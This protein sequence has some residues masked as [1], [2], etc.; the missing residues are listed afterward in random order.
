[1]KRGTIWTWIL[2]IVVGAGAV[3]LWKRTRAAGPEPPLPADAARLDPAVGR[4]VREVRAAV[5]RS[6]E[7][8]L[9]WGE[10]GMVYE[11]NELLD[12]AL[13]SYAR[14]AE[15]APDEVRWPYRRARVCRKLGRIPEAIAGMETAA[16][17]DP[18]VSVAHW[19]LGLLRL[20]TAD[21]PGAEANFLRATS[22]DP[23]DPAGWIGLARVHLLREDSRAAIEA[24]RRAIPL[25]ENQAYAHLLLGRALQLAGRTDE[26]LAELALGKAEDPMWP[27]PFAEEMVRHR[28]GFNV[29]LDHARKLIF[30]GQ[31]LS[32]IPLLENLRRAQPSDPAVINNLS[33][34]YSRAGRMQEARALL[35]EGLANEPASCTMRLNL[36]VV[37]YREGKLDAALAEIDRALALDPALALAHD[38]KGCYLFEA[39]RYPEALAAF[40]AELA[41][42]DRNVEVRLWIGENLLALHRN[43]EAAGTFEEL[44]R[45]QPGLAEAWFGLA[46]ARL[47]LR[48]LEGANAAL[49]ETRRLGPKDPARL[50]AAFVE[51]EKR[52]AAAP[53]AG[54][55]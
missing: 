38:L 47:G 53:A 28:V 17:L 18:R 27:D 35:E 15:L 12:P 52:R 10:L 41:C 33:D 9:A 25:R 11:A 22:V 5:L 29:T 1:M 40:R 26:A 42:D 7:S 55:R 50:A 21:L 2:V 3:I 31:P 23:K 48:E 13:P 20:E 4:R 51:L 8:P 19:Q 32:A 36:A 44:T 39:K 14:A 24:L 49:I 34:A 54:K 46:R 37:L 43:A 6:P 16:A 45:L 30:A